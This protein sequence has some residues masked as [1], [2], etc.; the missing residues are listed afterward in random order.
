MNDELTPAQAL[1][2][3]LREQQGDAAFTT[4]AVWVPEGEPPKPITIRRDFLICEPGQ[5]FSSRPAIIYDIIR[6]DIAILADPAALDNVTRPN[7]A[8]RADECNLVHHQYSHLDIPPRK[9]KKGDLL[10]I[11]YGDF[12]V[13][14]LERRKRLGP[15]TI[16]D[17]H[18]AQMREIKN[19]A[20]LCDIN[21]G[22]TAAMQRRALGRNIRPHSY[23]RIFYPD[24]HK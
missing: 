8:I 4:W 22:M 19:C 18:P 14:E 6:P 13:V 17:M 23:E 15:I 2:D 11:I 16:D 5:Y 21:G 24:G 7:R 20:D 3:M 10:T 12:M 9:A 1:A